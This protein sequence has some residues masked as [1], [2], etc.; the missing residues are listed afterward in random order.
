[1]NRHAPARFPGCRRRW[2]PTG[3]RRHATWCSSVTALTTIATW[4]GFGGNLVP[5]LMVSTPYGLFCSDSLYGDVNGNG[6]PELAVSRLS[7]HSS[8]DMVGLVNKVKWQGGQPPHRLEQRL[9]LGIGGVAGSAS[10]RPVGNRSVDTDKP[11]GGFL[12]HP[13]P[14]SLPASKTSPPRAAATF[15]RQPRG[16]A[17]AR[18]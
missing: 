6:L 12:S 17:D 14:M 18:M 2:R 9:G 11:T 8:A 7:G 15:R 1:M 3:Q 5:P 4:E 10:S 13:L 16:G